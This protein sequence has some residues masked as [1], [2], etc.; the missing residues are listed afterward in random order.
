MQGHFASNLFRI[1]RKYAKLLNSF[2]ANTCKTFFFFLFP[3]VVWA[4]L[5]LRR[6][7]SFETRHLFYCKFLDRLF[8]FRNRWRCLLYFLIDWTDLWFARHS[9]KKKKK[10]F[11]FVSKTDAIARESHLLEARNLKISLPAEVSATYIECQSRRVCFPRRVARI[12]I[13]IIYVYIQSGDHRTFQ[14]SG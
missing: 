10:F 3:Y 4:R 12:Y 9:T 11:L 5:D 7:H 13:Y 6:G 14:I 8:F 2:L 1:S